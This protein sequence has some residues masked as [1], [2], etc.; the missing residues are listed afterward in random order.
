VS[1]NWCQFLTVSF[2]HQNMS[3][4]TAVFGQSREKIVFFVKK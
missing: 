1:V 3:S 2:H 4:L